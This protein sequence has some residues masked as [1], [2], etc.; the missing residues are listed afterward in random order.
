MTKVYCLNCAGIAREALDRLKSKYNDCE[1]IYN[2]YTLKSDV[3]V[4]RLI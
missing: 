1:Y 4:G 3:Y 2:D